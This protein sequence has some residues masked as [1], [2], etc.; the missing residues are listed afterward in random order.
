[1]VGRGSENKVPFVAA[2]ELND[3]GRPI[4]IKMDRVSGSTSEA[5]KGLGQ[6][7]GCT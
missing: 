6:A 7:D 3:E 1:M 2:V 5:I 4:Q